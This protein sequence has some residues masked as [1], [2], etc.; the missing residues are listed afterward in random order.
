VFEN[1]K[2]GEYNLRIIHDINNNG[3]WDTGNYL[4]KIKPENIVHYNDTIKV[5]ANWVIREKI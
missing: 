1:V 2:P 4:K 5:R 3:K